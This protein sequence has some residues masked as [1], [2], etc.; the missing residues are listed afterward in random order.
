MP[1]VLAVLR[2]GRAAGQAPDAE[3][4][5]EGAAYVER[6]A[7]ALLREAWR[8]DVALTSP[9]RRARETARVLLGRIAQDLP[10]A[11][12]AEL[13]PDEDP[14]ATLAALAAMAPADGTVLIVSHLPQVA[15]LA[16]LL[17]GDEVEFLPGT[18]AEFEIGADFRSGRLRRRIGPEDL[19]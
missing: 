7:A 5:P 8:P 19:V 18:F 17:T 10:L 11:E 14:A 9:F 6:L 1:I 2:H 13:R 3:L 12:A 15:R 16:A 4:L